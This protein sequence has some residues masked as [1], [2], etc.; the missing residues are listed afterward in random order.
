MPATRAETDEY[1]SKLR[2]R[3]RSNTF[4][5]DKESIIRKVKSKAS[6]RER[7]VLPS[8]PENNISPTKQQSSL[9]SLESLEWDNSEESLSFA[10]R[11]DKQSVGSSVF[12]ANKSWNSTS[13]RAD[14]RRDSIDTRFDIS[15]I[16]DESLNF[17]LESVSRTNSADDPDDPEDF[18]DAI[19][20]PQLFASDSQEA[21]VIHTEAG[22]IKSGNIG[23][24][25]V[26]VNTQQSEN[27]FN[28]L[29]KYTSNVSN[30]NPVT[31]IVSCRGQCRCSVTSSSKP[32]Y[33]RTCDISVG[34]KAPSNY[35]AEVLTSPRPHFQFTI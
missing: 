3:A 7:W 12:D 2:P 1:L 28:L 4:P 17:D 32:V 20:S 13:S 11:T 23:E 8:V 9:N 6:R 27:E 31:Y 24:I 34:K 22:V 21:G 19:G 29:D 26:S 18:R 5:R 25:E 33:R 35:E 14:P 16:L 30:F 15:A 10:K